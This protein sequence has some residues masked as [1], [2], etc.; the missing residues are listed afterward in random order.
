MPLRKTCI[1]GTV[2]LQLYRRL[3]HFFCPGHGIVIDMG[4][5]NGV[6]EMRQSAIVI[7]R[8]KK[9]EKY[10]ICV[11]DY[12]ISF[13][14][15]RKE[16]GNGQETSGIVFYGHREKD[17]RKYTIYGAG[18]D[19][20]L[21]LF[22]R[23]ERLEEIGCR[24]T[25]T[26]PAFLVRDRD[27]TY[28]AK[29]YS[30]F[31][32]DNTEMQ[33]YLICLGWEE[34]KRAGQGEEAYRKVRSRRSEVGA[35]Q[36]AGAYRRVP[37]TGRGMR[38]RRSESGGRSGRGI[39]QA[40][41]NLH[42]INPQAVLSLQL[43]MIFIVLVAIVINSAN[44]YDKMEQLNQ[45]AQEVFFVMENQ[46]AEGSLE[47]AGKQSAEEGKEKEETA[48]TDTDVQTEA[49][50]D[51]LL[52]ENVQK[53]NAQADTAA[54]ADGSKERPA[55]ETEAETEEDAQMS[56]AS[57]G[58]D[59]ASEAGQT[60]DEADKEK[61]DTEAQTAADTQDQADPSEEEPATA[62][63]GVEALSRN[64]SRYYEVKHGDT[65]YKISQ[66]IYGDTSQVK[67]ICE[68]NEITDPD[69]IHYGQKI[70]LP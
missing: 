29:G 40:V 48:E 2:F 46:E 1:K 23:Y 32:Y 62:G 13:L 60:D 33:D 50:S 69:H 41:R 5:W 18:E 55:M 14:K 59:T 61:P 12:V 3:R 11:E 36:G 66:K 58:T 25:G 64:V 56:T 45:S 52:Q 16:R 15:K 42:R 54:A 47:T 44:S 39:G 38:S 35:R 21:D 6:S 24:L 67:K 9:D 28:E 68:L 37:E 43:G 51:T 19:G 70:I 17:G 8:G 34:D 49:P 27:G 26:E 53:E 63:E 30:V 10:E 31:Y 22:D 7:H 20:H 57:A 65:L 4:S